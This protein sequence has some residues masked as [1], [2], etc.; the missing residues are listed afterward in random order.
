[1]VASEAASARDPVVRARGVLAEVELQA[2]AA[3]PDAENARIRGAEALEVLEEAGDDLGRALYWRI[4]GY[5]FWAR[6]RSQEARDA[7]ERA[8]EYAQS[9][10]ADRIAWE[11]HALLLG[12]VVLGPTPVSEAML[13]ARQALESSPEGSLR[14]TAALRSLAVLSASEGRLDE[15][16]ELHARGVETFRAAGL[17]VTA[18]G[19]SMSA[20]AI[21]R[22]AGDSQAEELVLRAGYEALAELSDRYYLPT[23]AIYLADTIANR[24]VDADDEVEALCAVARE[25][26]ISG[27]LV[28]FVGFDSIEARML[29]RRGRVDE[30][31]ALGRRALE[32]VDEMD[33][34]E[35]RAKIRLGLAE[36]LARAGQ[37]DEVDRIGEEAV[38]IHTAKGDVTGAAWARRRLE[39]LRASLA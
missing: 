26:T 37:R 16:R 24:T 38:A 27:D 19:W 31:L 28:N 7:W 36:V 23:V 21:E 20:S 15:A 4:E 14:A 22:R 1:L 35:F 18:A 9:A 32:A 3:G 2:L 8:L 33:F 13:R 29:A 34:F 12:A 30:A 11:L 5:G 6:C 17:L 39:A 25:R 10:E